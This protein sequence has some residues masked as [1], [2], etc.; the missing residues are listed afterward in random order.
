MAEIYNLLHE[1]QIGGRRQRS[2]IDATM[3]LTH[4]I[5]QGKHAKEITTALFMDVSGAFDNVSKDRLLQT[6]REM[7]YP[8]PI[9]HWVDHFLSKR[10][11]ALAFDGSKE[12]LSPVLTGIPQGSP[13]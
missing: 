3:A 12:D 11:T 4:E 7:G 8:I 1:D 6:L 13:A 2:A 5:E 10:T 9:Q